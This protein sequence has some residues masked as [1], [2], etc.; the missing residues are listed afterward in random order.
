MCPVR[1]TSNKYREP[2]HDSHTQVTH[3]ADRSHAEHA[4]VPSRRN[5]V[6]GKQ[7][8]NWHRVVCGSSRL[9]VHRPLHRT[10]QTLH[11]RG[12]NTTYAELVRVRYTTADS[13]PRHHFVSLYAGHWSILWIMNRETEGKGR[14]Q[15]RV[16]LEPTRRCLRQ[17]TEM[18]NV[19]LPTSSRRED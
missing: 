1:H 7:C 13:L 11:P 3:V 9:V 19:Q 8:E 2:H 6:A 15:V 17:Q 14:S 12:P 16:A 4:T 10:A 18:R 5:G